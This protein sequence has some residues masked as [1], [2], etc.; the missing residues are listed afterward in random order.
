MARG[1]T[2][3]L[4]YV[5]RWPIGYGEQSLDRGQ[6]FQLGGQVNDEKLIRLGYVLP[7]ERGAERY[8]CAECGAEFVGIAERTAHGRD[9]HSGRIL[10]PE[11]EDRAIDRRERMLQEIAPLNLDKTAASAR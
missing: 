4:P 8:Q 3:A 7:L 6:V 5:A 11:E 10:S 9:R 1:A 2:E